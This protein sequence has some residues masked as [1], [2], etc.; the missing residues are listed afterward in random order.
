MTMTEG[1]SYHLYHHTGIF[2]AFLLGILV[3]LAT[4][5]GFFVAYIMPAP[6]I[7]SQEELAT[8]NWKNSVMATLEKGPFYVERGAHRDLPDVPRS[9]PSMLEQKEMQE[10]EARNYGLAGRQFP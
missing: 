8:F 9:I 5:F 4:V 10:R 3:C 2:L 1:A 6:S 7:T